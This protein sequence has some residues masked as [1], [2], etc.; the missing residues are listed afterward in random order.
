MKTK[1]KIKHKFVSSICVC[2]MILTTLIATVPI[3]ASAANAMVASGIATIKPLGVNS[4]V[5]PNISKNSLD[6]CSSIFFY[7]SSSSISDFKIS[8][9][10]KNGTT[11]KTLSDKKSF[12]CTSKSQGR[13]LPYKIGVSFTVKDDIIIYGEQWGTSSKGINYTTYGGKADGCY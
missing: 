4:Q 1:D 10:V 5:G 7:K 6:K 9:W 12:T 2:L 3:T 11:G 8:F 13:L